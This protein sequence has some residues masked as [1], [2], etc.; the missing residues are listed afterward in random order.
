MIIAVAGVRGLTANASYRVYFDQ[1]DPAM[2]SQSRFESEFA[3]QDVLL[4]IVTPPSINAQQ[5]A[6]L[7]ITND[8]PNNF[9]HW[10]K[11]VLSEG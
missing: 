11:S 8:L 1:S 7:T 9:C 4:L 2:Q 3:R 6:E 10:H 5:T